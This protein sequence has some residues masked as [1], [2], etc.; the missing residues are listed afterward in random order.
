MFS[1]GEAKMFQYNMVHAQLIKLPYRSGWV[2]FSAYRFVVVKFCNFMVIIC[3]IY[4]CL[5]VARLRQTQKNVEIHLLIFLCGRSLYCLI[6]IYN[7][8]IYDIQYPWRAM[9]WYF[10][11]YTKHIDWCTM[12]ACIG[13]VRV[14]CKR[15]VHRF[16]VHSTIHYRWRAFTKGGRKGR[17]ILFIA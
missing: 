1:I 9:L 11:P 2:W 15:G 6:S 13:E 14:E 3:I 5:C 17:T 8:F 7:K 4:R 10:S 16:W 12:R